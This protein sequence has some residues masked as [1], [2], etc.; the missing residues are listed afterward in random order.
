MAEIPNCPF[1]Q[2]VMFVQN[3]F[4]VECQLTTTKHHIIL[5]L[6]DQVSCRNY[7][8]C[9]EDHDEDPV[10]IVQSY[11]ELIQP[12]LDPVSSC[13]GEVVVPV[14]AR[15]IPH[16]LLWSGLNKEMPLGDYCKQRSESIEVSSDYKIPSVIDP[17][18]H[19]FWAT[20]KPS[21]DTEYFEDQD[22]PFDEEIEV[23]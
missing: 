18:H 15:V 3:F 23:E 21:V 22:I 8:P 1:C 11:E 16:H 5:Y 2:T 6:D 20:Y 9:Q 14:E 13:E 7:T 19:I 12:K 17:N 4:C 10:P